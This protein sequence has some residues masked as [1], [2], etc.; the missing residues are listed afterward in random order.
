MFPLIFKS[1]ML[2]FNDGKTCQSR[3]PTTFVFSYAVTKI[4]V[5]AYSHQNFADQIRHYFSC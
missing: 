5:S 4:V 3:L 2:K 1:N